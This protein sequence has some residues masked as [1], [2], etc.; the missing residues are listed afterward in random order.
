MPAS[1]CLLVPQSATFTDIS[2]DEVCDFLRD[3]AR[4]Y[5]VEDTK[6][7]MY[8]TYWGVPALK[9]PS[10]IVSFG[11]IEIIENRTLLISALSDVRMKTLLDVISP[12]NLGT[13]QIQRDP[14][15]RLGKPARKSV[16]GKRRRK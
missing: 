14:I 8:W 11:D 13:P 15:I 9:A 4:L 1:F 6:Q 3:D 7:R 10:G 12:L 5:C 2:G 16:R